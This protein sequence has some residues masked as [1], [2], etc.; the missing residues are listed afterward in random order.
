MRKS[1]I[2]VIIVAVVAALCLSLAFAGDDVQDREK[3]ATLPFNGIT[4][5][6]TGTVT[7]A[8]DPVADAT[9]TLSSGTMTVN[10]TTDPSG[11]YSL[12]VSAGTYDLTVK[13]I[14]YVTYTKSIIISADAVENVNLTEKTAVNGATVTGYV[15]S[16]DDFTRYDAT[17]VSITLYYKIGSTGTFANDYAKMQSATS[18]DVANGTF[19]INNV[20]YDGSSVKD[21]LVDKCYISFS[22]GNYNVADVSS[23]CITDKVVTEVVLY[24]LNESISSTGSFEDNGTYSLGSTISA[25]VTFSPINGVS[26]TVKCNTTLIEGATVTFTSETAIVSTTTDSDGKYSVYVPSGTYDLIVSK[27]GYVKSIENG[28]NIDVKMNI[29]KDISMSEKTNAN[30]STLKGYV[31][32]VDDFAKYPGST[33]SITLY[34][35]TTDTETDVFSDY[36]ALQSA[37]SITNGTFTIT[38][39]KYDS[40]PNKDTLVDR[41]YIRFSIDTYSVASISPLCITNE[42]VFTDPD[43]VMTTLYHLNEII[44]TT[45]SFEDNMEYSFGSVSSAGVII[46]PAKGT[47]S[48]TMGTVGTVTVTDSAGNI[49]GQGSADSNGK[50]EFTS[51][52]GKD[53]TLTFS[54]IGFKSKTTTATVYDDKIAPLKNK[55]DPVSLTE[56]ETGKAYVKMYIDGKTSSIKDIEQAKYVLYQLLNPSETDPSKRSYRAICEYSGTL[57]E[58]KTDDK[59]NGYYFEFNINGNIDCK[60]CFLSVQIKGYSVR[61]VQSEYME[62]NT[63]LITSEEIATNRLVAALSSNGTN[64]SRFEIGHD[65]TIGTCSANAILV[66]NATGTVKGNVVTNTE[67]PTILNGVKVSII[68]KENNSVIAY[69]ITANNGEYSITVAKGDYKIRYEIEGYVTYETTVTVYDESIYDPIKNEQPTVKLDAEKGEWFGMDLP[70][71]LL[72]LGGIIAVILICAVLFHRF[73]ILDKKNKVIYEDEDEDEM[74]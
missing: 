36:V 31:V 15:K 53:L 73:R 23:S 39:V 62:M 4:Y 25:G 17:A 50:Y 20:K 61:T 57:K 9:V 7:C 28:I 33:V 24:H 38:N 26:G 74:K 19:V 41:C 45:G 14:G 69:G 58:D 49:F 1:L 13:K 37:S 60:D 43:G 40:A 32:A 5:D 65:Y 66:D 11:N 22:V 18:I 71:A 55:Q 72:V 6:V 34:Y 63:S 42:K 27:D 21:T 48:G 70:H 10:G 44:S 16:L 8:T 47:V 59:V 46:E 30:G 3:E 52:V 12:S 54:S 56:I 64:S 51:L 29:V 68:D 67:N 35:R 2:P